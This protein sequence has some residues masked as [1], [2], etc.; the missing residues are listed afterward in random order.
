MMVATQHRDVART[1]RAAAVVRDRVVC[2]A[3]AG[4]TAAAGKAAPAIAGLDETPH[5]RRHP[6]TVV[7][8]V[9]A[10]LSTTVTVTAWLSVTVTTRPDA[11]TTAR[12]NTKATTRPTATVTT[13]LNAKATIPPNAMDVLSRMVWLWDAPAGLQIGQ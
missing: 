5:T 7:A 12:P 10:W 4:G 11:D 13:R 1:R 3:A 6:I 2:I 8:M 9:T